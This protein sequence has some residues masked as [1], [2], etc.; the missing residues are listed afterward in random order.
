MT[1]GDGHGRA[2]WRCAGAGWCPRARFERAERCQPGPGQGGRGLPSQSS[3]M[4][5][6]IHLT[7]FLA[8]LEQVPRSVQGSPAIL[9]N[10]QRK[11]A[12]P[13]PHSCRAVRGRLIC[14]GDPRYLCAHLSGGHAA[15]ARATARFMAV[16]VR[17]P[18]RVRRERHHRRARGRA[19][20]DGHFDSDS[21]I[22]RQGDPLAGEP[23]NYHDVV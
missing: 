20:P 16:L 23:W 9:H 15:R 13:S 14:V 5:G 2:R 12:P 1:D 4:S 11:R 7:V 6:C 8:A 10:R 19:K 17:G 18:P 22:A 21:T 3:P